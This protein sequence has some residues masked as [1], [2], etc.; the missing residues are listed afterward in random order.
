MFERLVAVF[1]RE[2]RGLASL[3]GQQTALVASSAG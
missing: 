3:A 2:M 1:A